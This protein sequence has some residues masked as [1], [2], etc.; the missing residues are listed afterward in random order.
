M[1]TSCSKK[2]EL[3]GPRPLNQNHEVEQQENSSHRLVS[4]PILKLKSHK[5][6]TF[7]ISNLE[8]ESLKK[9]TLNLKQNS[10]LRSKMKRIIDSNSSEK[11]SIND[12]NRFEIHLTE[13][14]KTELFSGLRFEEVNKNLVWWNTNFNFNSVYKGSVNHLSYSISLYNNIR[15][16]FFDKDYF[17]LYRYENHDEEIQLSK[18]GGKSYELKSNEIHFG[19]IG[20]KL[21]SNHFIIYEIEDFIFEGLSLKKWKREV[22]KKKSLL[23]VS[24][25]DFEKVIYINDGESLLNA[26]G[27]VDSSFESSINGN[28]KKVFAKSGDWKIIGSQNLVE[29]LSAGKVIGL[30]LNDQSEELPKTKTILQMTEEE[31]VSFIQNKND[32]ANVFIQGNATEYKVVK[33]NELHPVYRTEEVHC[34]IRSGVCMTYRELPVERS[35]DV[36]RRRVEEYQMTYDAS[37]VIDMYRIRIGERTYSLKEFKKEKLGDFYLAE[38]II[39]VE[40][41]PFV[42][43]AHRRVVEITILD[44]LKEVNI[45]QDL[46][47]CHLRH[48]SRGGNGTTRT[49]IQEY[50]KSFS[51]TSFDSIIGTQRRMNVFISY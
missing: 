6:M 27:R 36:Y 47:A 34:N 15:N 24:A 19:Q 7:T 20:N 13:Q 45:A 32:S 40:I 17:D 29:S 4:F 38:G 39:N 23:L 31:I 41:F 33:W 42:G 3:K 12:L 2:N 44:S 35:C 5:E 11:L 30:F 10:F 21:I 48:I 25:K 50:L 1:I 43:L 22:L 51:P 8:T 26:L 16:D 14:S 9:K 49:Y 18:E 46:G 37:L 28:V